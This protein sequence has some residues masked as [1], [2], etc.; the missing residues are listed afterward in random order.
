MLAPMDP[1]ESVKER[2]ERMQGALNERARRLFAASEALA[3]GWGGVAIVARATGIAPSTIGLGKAEVRRLEESGLPPLPLNRSRRAG[4]GRN[5]L[6][7]KDPTLLSDL[8]RL[9]EPVTR[10]EP[11]CRLRWAA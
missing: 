6:A 2:F 9:V 4:G 11:Q 5:K 3:I 10:G 8:E 7:D 1:V